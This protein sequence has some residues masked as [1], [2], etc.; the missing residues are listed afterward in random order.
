MQCND[1]RSRALLMDRRLCDLPVHSLG[2]SHRRHDG[3]S[4]LVR[5]DTIPNLPCAPT[6]PRT[7]GHEIC[8]TLP[9]TSSRSPRAARLRELRGIS[10]M[11]SS[12]GGPR[13]AA[14]RDRQRPPA[15][16]GQE[17]VLAD[18]PR[19]SAPPRGRQRVLQRASR[20][21]GHHLGH[22]ALHLLG[23]VEDRVEQD[24]FRARLCHLAQTSHAGVGWPVDGDGLQAGQLE[25]RVEAVQ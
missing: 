7:A 9:E 4:R 20:E 16:Q 23:L 14:R 13:P 5:V 17:V 21:L 11:T 1:G 8:D 15:R 12:S 24:Q 3:R 10:R 2:G 19:V 22:Q 18:R 6:A 25:E